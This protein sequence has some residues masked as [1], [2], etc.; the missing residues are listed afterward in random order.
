MVQ[1]DQY[2]FLIFNMYLQGTGDRP[3]CSSSEVLGLP[4]LPFP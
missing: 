1:D 4:F 3:K 2:S